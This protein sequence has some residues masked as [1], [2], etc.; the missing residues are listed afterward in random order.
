MDKHWFTRFYQEQIDITYVKNMMVT[1]NYFIH[2][3]KYGKKSY[4]EMLLGAHQIVSNGYVGRTNGSH[5]TEEISKFRVS[6]IPLLSDG[7]VPKLEK[8]WFRE[9]ELPPTIRPFIP[10]I[11][12]ELTH[13]VKNKEN[14][15]FLYLP[16]A[17]YL[18]YYLYTLNC[19][20]DKLKRE[21]TLELLAEYIQL[22]VIAHPFEKI[23]FSICMSQI[24]ALLSLSGYKTIYHGYLDFNCFLYDYDKIENI[25]I[26]K[27]KGIE[28]IKE[29]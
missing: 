13:W 29:N 12:T 19:T 4:A 26:N 5:Q 23:N 16:D 3:F 10:K 22:F 21:I 28:Y 6:G 17:K 27:V 8:N 18:P 9:L 1:T 14:A 24:N 20:M 25:F 15:Y 11:P 2:W 7:T